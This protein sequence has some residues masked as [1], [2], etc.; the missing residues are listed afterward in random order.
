MSYLPLRDSEGKYTTPV[1]FLAIQAVN[2]THRKLHQRLTWKDAGYVWLFTVITLAIYSNITAKPE[3]LSPVP[4]MFDKKTNQVRIAD[5]DL[6]GTSLNPL[7]DI[8]YTLVKKTD[9]DAYTLPGTVE[10]EIKAVFGKDGEDALA[11]A[12]CESHLRPSVCNDGMNSNGT[13][14]CGLFQVN[15]I[16]G[17]DRKYLTN[18]TINIQVAKMLFDDQGWEPWRSS[19]ACHHMLDSKLARR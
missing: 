19:N 8:T 15:S 2:R 10:R 11:V 9:A 13:A 4:P 7:P 17:I 18:Q 6:L 3:L 1:R 5:I 14:D 12:R 16:H